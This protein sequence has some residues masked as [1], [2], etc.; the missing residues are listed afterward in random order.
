MVVRKRK[1]EVGSGSGSGFPR[2]GLG[3]AE[4]QPLFEAGSVPRETE[5]SE[6]ISYVNYLHKLLGVEGDDQNHVPTL[7]RG[8]TINEGVLSVRSAYPQWL[9][10]MRNMLGA[11]HVGWSDECVI[12]L[13]TQP[14]ALL[15]GQVGVG[16]TRGTFMFP[17]LTASPKDFRLGSTPPVYFDSEPLK[18]SNFTCSSFIF[19]YYHS[20]SALEGVDFK[21]PIKNVASQISDNYNIEII[22]FEEG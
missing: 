15:L 11:S 17:V 10:N 8:L 16:F 18:G 4:L 5:I 14:G 2:L 21:L 3:H 19:W 12:F 6:L 13:I 7:G 9:I 1:T 20:E 22:K